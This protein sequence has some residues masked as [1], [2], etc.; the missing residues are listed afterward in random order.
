MKIGFYSI[1]EIQNIKIVISQSGTHECPS[2]SDCENLTG[3]YKCEEQD[4]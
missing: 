1:I 3:T 4:F 2:A